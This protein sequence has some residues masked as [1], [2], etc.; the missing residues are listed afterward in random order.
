MD[1]HL[2]FLRAKARQC[3]EFA[4]YHDGEAAAGLLTMADDLEAKAEEVEHAVEALLDPR[5]DS[6]GPRPERPH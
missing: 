2:D 4:R 1:D 6:R 5:I 3:R